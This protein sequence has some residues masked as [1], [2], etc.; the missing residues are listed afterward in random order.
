MSKYPVLVA[1]KDL[2]DCFSETFDKL[3]KKSPVIM[4]EETTPQTNSMFG[5]AL[6]SADLKNGKGF[7]TFRDFK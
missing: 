1:R 3:I 5:N 2:L 4:L 7:S 6:K